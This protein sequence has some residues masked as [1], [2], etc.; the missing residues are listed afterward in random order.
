MIMITLSHKSNSSTYFPFSPQSG[1]RRICV[2]IVK[3]FAYSRHNIDSLVRHGSDQVDS[4]S[5]LGKL[6]V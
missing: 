2:E 4:Q 1:S 6:F 3:S 5:L